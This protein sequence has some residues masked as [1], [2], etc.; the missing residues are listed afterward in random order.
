MVGSLL[1]IAS[2]TRVDIAYA[3]SELSRFVANPGK[4]HLEAAKGVFRYLKS[5][6]DFAI[7]YGR[8]RVSQPPATCDMP[9]NK[10]WGYVDSDWAGC[11]DSRKSTSGYCF[12]LNGAAISWRSKRQPV[13]ALSTAEAEFISAS[14]MVQEVIYLRKLL[15]NLGFPKK[16][17]L[18]L[19]RIKATKFPLSTPVFGSVR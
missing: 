16:K 5:T 1:Y 15:E 18:C 13:V 6:M 8:P 11:P 14:A 7:E 10:L 4:S 19:L 3:V 17:K 2:W 12:M 9:Q